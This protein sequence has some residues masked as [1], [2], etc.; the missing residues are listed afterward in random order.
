VNDGSG[1]SSK[2]PGGETLDLYAISAN[3]PSPDGDDRLLY[4]RQTITHFQEAE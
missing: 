4:G 1:V 3:D 2:R